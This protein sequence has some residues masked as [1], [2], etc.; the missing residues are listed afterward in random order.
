M[1]TKEKNKQPS[2]A[3]FS[4]AT[5]T[6]YD[7]FVLFWQVTRIKI[8]N[9]ALLMTTYQGSTFTSMAVTKT[10]TSHVKNNLI[11]IK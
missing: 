5:R 9:D 3:A 6:S 2:L 10:V 11:M 4:V 1:T 7:V 8:A